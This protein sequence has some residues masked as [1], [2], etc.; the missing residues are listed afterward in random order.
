MEMNC[1]HCLQELKGHMVE[2]GTIVRRKRVD[3]LQT[4]AP[5]SAQ[6]GIFTKL[7]GNIAQRTGGS[8]LGCKLC[9]PC[10]AMDLNGKIPERRNDSERT[11]KLRRRI[12]SF[13]AHCL[14]NLPSATPPSTSHGNEKE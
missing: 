4:D 13:P 9:Y 3:I 14:P 12:D 11:N 8:I 2:A 7:F 1:F 5:N 6:L 10:T